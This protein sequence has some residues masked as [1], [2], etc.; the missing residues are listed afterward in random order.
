MLSSIYIV[1]KIV[2]FVYHDH[3]L[4]DNF[5]IVVEPGNRTMG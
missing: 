3:I 4:Q 5:M 1:G 2:K